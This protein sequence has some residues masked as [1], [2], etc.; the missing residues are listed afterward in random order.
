MIHNF[1]A[2]IAAEYGILEAVL[3]YN[4]H[5][6]IEKNKA[7]GKNFYDGT[8]WTYNSTK[9]FSSL[10]PYASERQIKAALKHLRDEEILK[11]GN[12]NENTYDRTL[13]Y[14]LT[15]KGFS[16]VQNGTMQRTKSYNAEDKTEQSNEQNGTMEST[17][18][19]NPSDADVRPIPNNKP[20]SKPDVNNQFVSQSDDGQ[21]GQEK[22]DT[23]NAYE[24]VIKTNIVYD[25]LIRAYPHEQKLV[26]EMVYIMLDVVLTKGD[27]VQ[28]RGEEKPRA[29]VSSVLLKLRYD[30][31]EY[32]LE[33]Y[34]Q[35]MNRIKN[36]QAYL[37]TML[38]NSASETEAHYTNAVRADYWEG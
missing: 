20:Y 27:Y 2:D 30:N 29:L 10:F 5:Y 11:T 23:I 15:E 38:Y 17:E 26:D 18:T 14:A 8:Y 19:S 9:A 28:I 3:L 25:D 16:I 6:W 36:K 33:K 35:Q 21:D 13:W 1:D 32:V 22:I 31:I 37:L 7:N 4:I 24:N 12:Y 34:K